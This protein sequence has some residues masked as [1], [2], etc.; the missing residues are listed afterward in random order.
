M[1]VHVRKKIFNV[2]NFLT[3]MQNVISQMCKLCKCANV[4]MCKCAK[5]RR[6]QNAQIC[7]AN[8]FPNAEITNSQICTVHNFLNASFVYMCELFFCTIYNY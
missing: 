6:A 8:Y 5:N 4:Q 7:S 3:K 2:Q 1:F